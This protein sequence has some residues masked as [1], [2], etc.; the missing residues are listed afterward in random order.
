M[1]TVLLTPFSLSLLLSLFVITYAF[2]RHPLLI[3]IYA[4]YIII[5][6]KSTA[7]LTESENNN[8]IYI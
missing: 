8:N 4:L 3:H 1:A 7:I 2:C 5:G 6:G